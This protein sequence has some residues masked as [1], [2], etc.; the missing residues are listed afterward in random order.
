[1]LA[2]TGTG[3]GGQSSTVKTQDW[4]AKLLDLPFG[5]VLVILVGLIVLAVAGYLYY[6]AYSANFQQRLSLTG[7]GAQMKKG[8][9]ALGRVGYAALGVV[10]T[11]ISIFLIVAAFQHNASKAVGLDGALKD[12][13]HQPFGLILLGI[14]ALGLIAY[15]LYSFVEA[16]Y[17]RIGN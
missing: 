15:G 10:F 8:A 16:R 14:V 7:L 2:A 6:K 5:R 4:T 9:I 13:A 3:N 11:V 17:R 1:M 12:L